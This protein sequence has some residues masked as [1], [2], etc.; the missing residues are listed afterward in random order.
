MNFGLLHLPRPERALAEMHRV[1]RAGGRAAFTVWRSAGPEEA[2]A[3]PWPGRQVPGPRWTAR[4]A[5]SPPGA[6]G[7]GGLP[8]P[9]RL[10]PDLHGLRD[11]GLTIRGPRP[12]L[13]GRLRADDDGAAGRKYARSRRQAT[14]ALR[15]MARSD[16][17]PAA[18]SRPMPEWRTS[19]AVP[20]VTTSPPGWKKVSKSDPNADRSGA[21]ATVVRRPYDPSRYRASRRQMGPVRS[22]RCSVPG[23][24][25]ATPSSAR[26]A[27]TDDGAARSAPPQTMRLAARRIPGIRRAGRR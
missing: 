4:P 2:A 5:R 7:S 6:R 25:T 10:D 18:C 21:S 11:D 12:R 27:S 13:R 17:S 16:T 14:T 19:P 1:L 3:R 22:Y 26:S 23:R 24:W 8:G 9:G 15:V 20:L